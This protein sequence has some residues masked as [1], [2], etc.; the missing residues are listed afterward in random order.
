MKP[1][2]QL[3]LG[4]LE[5]VL[6]NWVRLQHDY[7]LFA[8]VVD[9]HALTSRYEETKEV[10][11]DT[12]EVAID[13]MAAGLDPERCTL[14]VQSDVKEHAELHLLLSMITPQGWLDRV[15]TYKEHQEALSGERLSY[16]LYGYPVLMAADIL[17][18]KANVVPVGRDQL[19]HLEFARELCRRFNRLY[20]EVFP[21]PDG[22]LEERADV[23]PGLDGRK[24]SKSY[25]NT[26]AIA[27]G[28]DV[29]RQKVM[30]MF[31]DPQKIRRNDP[32]RPEICPVYMWQRVF[33][34]E[35]EEE[36]ATGCRAGTLGCVADKRDLAEAVIRAMEPIHSRRNELR[37]NLDYVHQVLRE[38]AERA[39]E[40]AHATMQDVREA[41]GGIGLRL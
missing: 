9:W 6:R 22:L 12:L 26:I 34:P 39:R 2:G 3:H 15:P 18:Y 4:H 5:G 14:F 30:Q 32:G 10:R 27:D 28:P 41:M 7:E 16:G 35:K 21:E 19:P 1:T 38:G 17:V 11:A 25:G 33:Q 8:C 36:V 29:I 37:N 40:V 23:L 20:G 24:M 31:T 13:Y